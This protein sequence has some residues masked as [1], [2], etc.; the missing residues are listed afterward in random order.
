MFASLV[1]VSAGGLNILAPIAAAG[2]LSVKTSAGCFSGRPDL[3]VVWRCSLFH[4]PLLA[5]PKMV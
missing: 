2:N 3:H 5:S 4:G 1:L